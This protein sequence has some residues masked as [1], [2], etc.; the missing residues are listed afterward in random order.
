MDKTMTE[1]VLSMDWL[2]TAPPRRALR[3]IRP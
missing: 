2:A 1:K 3:Q